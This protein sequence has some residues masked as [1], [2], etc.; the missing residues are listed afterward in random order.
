MSLSTSS[1]PLPRPGSWVPTGTCTRGVP[2]TPTPLIRPSSLVEA[3]DALRL[4]DQVTAEV[5]Q[6]QTPEAPALTVLVTM[7]A[8][9]YR[10]RAGDLATTKQA[11]E[12]CSSV[13]EGLAGVDPLI[14]ATFYRVHSAYDKANMAFADYYRH[15]LLYLAST[16]TEELPAAEAQ[17]RAHDLCV[18]ALLSDSLYNF[19]ELLSHPILESLEGHPM[20]PLRQLLLAFNAG[21]HEAL[22]RAASFISQHPGLKAHQESLRQKICLMAL[23][24]ALFRQIKTSRTIALAAIAAA[25]RVPAEQAEFLLIKALSLKLIRGTLRQPEGLFQIEWVQPRV[26]DRQQVEELLVGIQAWRR[27]VQETSTLVHSLL[28]ESLKHL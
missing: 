11:I 16:R 19:G 5:R 2:L 9:H 27:R 18:A 15:T 1:W 26:L 10:L 4:L 25:T 24:E 8:A 23:V 21:Q 28:P 20:A 12:A 14:P 22:D 7:E 17:E 3:Q 6:L 13:A